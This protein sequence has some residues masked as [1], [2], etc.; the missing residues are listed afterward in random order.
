MRFRDFGAYAL[1]A[2]ALV[3]PR[4]A[5]ADDVSVE[6]IGKALAGQTRPGLVLYANKA[7]VSAKAQLTRGDGTPLTLRAGRIAPGAKQELLF[8]APAGTHSYSGT[9]HVEFIDGTSG[10]MPL[11]FEVLVSDGVR[12]QVREDKLDLPAGKLAFTFTGTASRCEYDVAFD[13]KPARHGWARYAGEAPG[14]ELELSWPTHGADDK[15]LRIQLTCHDAEGFFSPT[16]ELFPWKIDVPHE[17]VV[18]A[19]GKWDVAADEAKKLDAAQREIVSV[20]KRYQQAL[21]LG[22]QKIG[23]YVIGHTDSVGDPGS[24]RALSLN[25][26]KAIAGYFRARGLSLPI[27]YVG[28]GEDAPAVETPDETDEPRNRRAEYIVSVDAPAGVK[29]TKL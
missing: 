7:I 15:V 2:A 27:Y 9:L 10:E 19:T 16:V 23:L 12:V 17:D 26:A 11:S 6:L 22:N 13:G 20:L 28:M 18:F 25:R 1:V 29:W 8:D 24:N 3:A 5:A 21:K 4:I 14:T